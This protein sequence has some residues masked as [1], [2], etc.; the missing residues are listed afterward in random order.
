MAFSADGKT[1]TTNATSPYQLQEET[2][3]GLWSVQ[4]GELIRR[5]RLPTV[6]V[7]SL[8][9]APDGRTLL[10]TGSEPLVRLW[11]A[12]LPLVDVTEQEQR[13]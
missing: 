3:I 7:N 12:P 10:T 5:L 11:D 2:T 1:L 13:L 4:T 9:F 8:L 6:H